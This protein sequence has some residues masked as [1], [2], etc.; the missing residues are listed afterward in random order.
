M[1][2]H[3]QSTRN[4]AHTLALDSTG[5]R[6]FDHVW[7]SRKEIA[8]LRSVFGYQW[9]I[10]H[11][12]LWIFIFVVCAFYL[13]AGHNPN[14]YTGNIDVAV[15]DFDGEQAGGF[16]LD[17]FRATPPGNLT[18]RWRYKYPN[19]YG[20]SVN[21]IQQAVDDGQVW[22]IVVLRPNTTSTI[23]KSLLALINSTTLVTYPFVNTP[24]VLVIYDEGRNA[25]TQNIF[26]LPPIRAAIATANNQYGQTLRTTIISNLSFTSRSS[27]NRTL[28]L[29]N[30]LRLQ[31]L[32]ANPFVAEYNNL[33]RALPYVGLFESNII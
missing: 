31:H 28:Q 5:T 29:Q 20:N 32:L 1:L 21:E 19:D 3:Q 2:K 23:N 16:F 14:Q 26:V 11:A 6:D 18:L 24:P 10:G 15:V 4:S 17:A 12:P 8:T 25:F 22:A 30:T 9:I 33:H 13:G 27:T 7:S